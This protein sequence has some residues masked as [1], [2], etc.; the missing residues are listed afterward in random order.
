MVF[1]GLNEIG[2]QGSADQQHGAGEQKQESTPLLHVMIFIGSG[3]IINCEY[4]G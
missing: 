2:E 3:G 4:N 1:A